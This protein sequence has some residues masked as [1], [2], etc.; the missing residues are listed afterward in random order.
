MEFNENKP[1]YLQLAD[2]IMDDVLQLDLNQDN[3]LLSVREYAAQVGV[4]PNTVNRAYTWLQDKG[5]IFNRR[6]IGYFFEA[7]AKEKIIQQRKKYFMEVELPDFVR[8]LIKLE[9]DPNLFV[10]TYLKYKE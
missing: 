2:K 10:K 9:I 8:R 7:D 1:I 3:R 6:G 4:N 5:I